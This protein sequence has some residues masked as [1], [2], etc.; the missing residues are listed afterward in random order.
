VP[1]PRFSQRRT[2]PFAAAPVEQ[3]SDSNLRPE[4]HEG[5]LGSCRESRLA[6]LKR[7][8]LSGTYYVPAGEIS[9]ALVE[10]HLKR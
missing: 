9:A 7:Q 4:I 10:K 3:I 2:E 5:D 8:Y 1:K 6:E